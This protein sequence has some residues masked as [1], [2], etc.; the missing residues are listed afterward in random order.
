MIDVRKILDTTKVCIYFRTI[1]L[2]RTMLLGYAKTKRAPKIAKAM[3][4][5]K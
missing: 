5:S 4:C 3:T 1:A 2:I